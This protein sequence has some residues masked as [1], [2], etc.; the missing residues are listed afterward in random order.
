MEGQQ[1]PRNRS[2]GCVSATMTARQAP[3]P[4]THS[5]HCHTTEK[6]QQLRCFTASFED[7]GITQHTRTGTYNYAR[8][9]DMWGPPQPPDPTSI[10]LH[11]GVSSPAHKPHWSASPSV[12]SSSLVLGS[13]ER[14]SLWLQRG[15]PRPLQFLYVPTKE[16]G[17]E[18]GQNF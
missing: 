7:P 17:Y 8:G 18:A 2:Q 4:G 1:D 15:T 3:Q 13:K 16:S 10:S 11:E 5:H 9:S 6:N 14:G 12:P